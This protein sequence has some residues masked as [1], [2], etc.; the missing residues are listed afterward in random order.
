MHL[1]G[2]TA[3]RW[4]VQSL[5]QKWLGAAAAAGVIRTERTLQQA[6]WAWALLH[7]AAV[8]MLDGQLDLVDGPQRAGNFVDRVADGL[9]RALS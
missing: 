9:V 7:G 2:L 3:S 4:R 8:L 1:E 5:L 6:A